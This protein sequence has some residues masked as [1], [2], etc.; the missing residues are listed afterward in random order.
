MPASSDPSTAGE[1]DHGQTFWRTD[2]AVAATLP[3]LDDS[4]VPA[5]EEFRLLAEHLPVLCWIAR[6]DGYIT[7]YNRRWH[8]YCGTTP[9]A[10]EGWGWQSVHDPEELPTVTQ[11]WAG[12]IAT[13]EPFE[14]VFPLR[15]ADGRFRP[16]LTRISPLRDASG[17]VVRWFGTNVEIGPQVRAEAALS[18]S[19]ARYTVLTEA[20]PQ[21]VWSTLPD[22]HHDY[23]NDQ[24]YRFTGVPYGST[25]GEGWNGVFHP[26]DQARAWA[27]WRHSLETGDTY[28]IEYRLR[29]HSG[30]YRWILGRALPV[31]DASGA[32]VRWIGTCTDIHDAKMAAEQ[33]EI[34]S[35]ELSHRIKNIFAVISG[36][37]GLSARDE[38]AAAGFARKLTDR[39]M[40]LGRAHEFARPHSDESRPQFEHSTL[41]SMLD[42]LLQP[43]RIDGSPRAQ[44]SGGDIE[45]DDQAATPIALVFHELATNASKYGALSVADGHVA[46]TIDQDGE[47]IVIRWRERGGPPVDGPPHRSG[48]GSRLAEL[49]VNQ[50]LGGKI[51][52][53]W[54]RDGLIV[55]IRVRADRL[56][57]VR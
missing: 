45:V 20:M 48:F 12:S 9:Q 38:P 16:F 51:E 42:D 56:R 28:E 39:I 26:D 36:L 19:E 31:R 21:M 32:I 50:Q 53:E 35:R 46:L 40:A 3:V 34:L 1:S 17:A 47:D 14:M 55:T 13:G 30:D 37:I 24:W 6:G 22:G 5:A 18:S 4:A 2:D 33:N 15:G 43:Y 54:A 57:R 7:W 52:R 41:A 44:I 27:V 11:R 25:D 49:S 8:D 10:M 29:H 23:F